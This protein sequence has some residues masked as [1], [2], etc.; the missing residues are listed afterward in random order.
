MK[1]SPKQALAFIS[2]FIV[3]K[4]YGINWVLMAGMADY[5]LSEN[6][7]LVRSQ[8]FG[9]PDYPNCILKFLMDIYR[10]NEDE[11]KF[12]IS[13]IVRDGDVNDA[14]D[15]QYAPAFEALEII[16]Q[17]GAAMPLLPS[18]IKTKYLNVESVPHDFYRELIEQINACYQFGCYPAAQILVRKLLENSLIDILRK[19]YS[20]TN[21]NLF[22]DTS[23][24]RFLDFSILLD[25]VS[26][27]LKDFT[28]VKDSFNENL[29]ERINNY[30]DQG[31]SSA[32]NIN[33]D[34][35]SVGSELD[36]NRTDLNFIVKSLFRT[37][38][39]L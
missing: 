20:M 35:Q 12:I 2:E 15:P 8:S 9:D 19:R 17:S 33:L 30:R 34:I 16:P 6:P 22:Y 11:A 37:W 38:V 29:I 27:N 39:N 10:R 24:G 25:N 3:E 23:K 7:R 36:K 1:R 32:H 5:E 4:R 28:H 31:N 18:I 14:L 26:Q 13:Q 21:V